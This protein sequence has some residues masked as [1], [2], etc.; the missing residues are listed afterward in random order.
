[1]KDGVRF[2]RINS[3][4]EIPSGAKGVVVGIHAPH[5][6]AFGYLVVEYLV[7]WR[8][9]KTLKREWFDSTKL[10]PGADHSPRAAFASPFNLRDQHT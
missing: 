3:E 2:F 5:S 1:M 10:T 8:E 7:E 9:G 6:I 4:V